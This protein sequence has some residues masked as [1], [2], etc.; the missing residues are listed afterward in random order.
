MN[1]N[2]KTKISDKRTGFRVKVV[3][4][5]PSSVFQTLATPSVDVET[6][7]SESRLEGETNSRL[8]TSIHVNIEKQHI[9]AKN[10]NGAK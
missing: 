9:H 2:P 6:K 3:T 8:V 10:Q 1:L 5:N 4:G 7:N